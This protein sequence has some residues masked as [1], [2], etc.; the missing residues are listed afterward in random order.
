[1]RITIGHTELPLGAYL[2]VSVAVFK[3]KQRPDTKNMSHNEKGT[4]SVNNFDDHKSSKSILSELTV[5]SPTFTFIE[6][7]LRL[8]LHSSTAKIIQS[9]EVSNPQL[10][11]QFEKRSKVNF[12]EMNLFQF[13]LM[14][15]R[16]F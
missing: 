1:M 6:Y 3:T 4:M 7:F 14:I 11:L 13:Q 12:E 10:T 8:N 15:Y 16:M 5:D 2:Q 9:F